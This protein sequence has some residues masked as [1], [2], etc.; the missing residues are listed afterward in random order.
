MLDQ[1]ILRRA[2]VDSGTRNSLR[3]GTGYVGVV[4]AILVGLLGMGID[5][6][7]LALIAG[8]LSIGLGFG[9]Q[10]IANNFV[11]GLILLIERPVKVGDW[12]AVGTNEGIVKRISVRATEIETFQR[13]SVLVPNSELISQAV[14]N[15]TFKDHT[16]RLRDQLRS[17]RT[18]MPT[19]WSSGWRTSHAAIPPCSPHRRP[20]PS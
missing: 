6:S 13:S 15:W 19:R 16:G 14:V 9:L 12:V 11:S 20:G 17:G 4:V 18:R 1:R 3:T 5:L 10:T 7:K 2:R 8:A